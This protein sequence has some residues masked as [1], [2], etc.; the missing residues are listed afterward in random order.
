MVEWA[1]AAAKTSPS[2]IPF[3]SRR[4][5]GCIPGVPAMAARRTDMGEIREADL[6]QDLEP[7][8]RLWLDT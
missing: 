6:P 4:S 5:A 2:R 8:E 3:I 7:V 1:T